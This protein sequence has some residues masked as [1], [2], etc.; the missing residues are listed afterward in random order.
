MSLEYISH[1][2]IRIRRD[3]L[4]GPATTRPQGRKRKRKKVNSTE[5]ERNN[6]EKNQIKL[7]CQSRTLFR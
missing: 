3:Y 7:C 6:K 5:K 4:C 1:D 2:L